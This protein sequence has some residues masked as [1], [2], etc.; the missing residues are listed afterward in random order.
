M[1]VGNDTTRFDPFYYLHQKASK[2][3]NLPEAYHAWKLFPAS[4][5]LLAHVEVLIDL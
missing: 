2:I 1:Q 5:R 3:L 4:I